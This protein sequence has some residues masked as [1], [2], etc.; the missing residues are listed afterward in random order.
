MVL[1]EA[2]AAGMEPLE[3]I[4]NVERNMCSEFVTHDP[5]ALFNTIV[6]QLRDEAIIEA[7]DAK[8]RQ[9]ANRRDARLV[10]GTGRKKFLARLTRV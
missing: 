6:K 4:R 8:H 3:F 7:N 1:V 5:D 10:G 9:T 2:I